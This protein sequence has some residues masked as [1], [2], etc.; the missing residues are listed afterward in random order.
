MNNLMTGL[1]LT[2]ICS[3]NMRHSKHRTDILYHKNKEERIKETK[4]E[5]IPKHAK[6]EEHNNISNIEIY[7]NTLKTIT[8]R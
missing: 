8:K 7:T 6:K 1:I 5:Y 3:N 4:E 2:N